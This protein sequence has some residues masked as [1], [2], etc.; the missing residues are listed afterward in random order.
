VT[1][2]LDGE[3]SVALRSFLDGGGQASLNRARD[4]GRKALGGGLG[5]LEVA[6]LHQR[7]IEVVVLATPPAQRPQFVKAAG[8]FLRE[9]LSAFDA[10]FRGQRAVRDEL[11]GLHG[12]LARE[13]EATERVNREFDAFCRSVSHD[14]RG[15]L[16][17]IDG[18]SQALLEDYDEKLDARGKEF[19]RYLSQSAQRM[20]RL[21]EGLL[22]LGRVTRSELSPSRID[23]SA[24][25]Q[26][27]CDRLGAAEPG[28]EVEVVVED[29]VTAWGDPAL[30]EAVLENLLANAWKFTTSRQEARIE[31]GCREDVDTTTYFVRDNGAGYDARFAG[32]LFSAFQRLHSVK[33]FPGIGIGLAK[34][35]RI[36]H[37][38]GGRVWSEGEVN[39]GA[40]FYFTLPA[41]S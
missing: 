21:I 39:R 6:A 22:A 16:H 25:V 34:V 27:V 31:F 15:P 7:T 12:R 29:S 19:L 30:V 14:L 2:P 37:L 1:E 18:L 13:R 10:M 26:T 28:R 35:Q 8:D 11:S 5:V 24:L 36:V 32:K 23:M 17:G 4:L 33:E 20:E 9:L 40:T 41:T 3:Y 38:H